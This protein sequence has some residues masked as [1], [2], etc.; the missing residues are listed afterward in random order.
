LL[1][2]EAA[3]TGL[4]RLNRE[5]SRQAGRKTP[6]A[7][8]VDEWNEFGWDAERATFAHND[9]PEPYD[10]AH[11]L[12]SAGFLN[13]FL[14]HAADVGMANYSPTINCRGFV[15]ADRRGVLLRPDYYVF[16][17]Y[18]AGMGGVALRARVQAAA[19]EHARAPLLDV[20]AVRD[21]HGTVHLFAVNRHARLATR[22]RI[23][24]AHFHSGR[25]SAQQLTAVSLESYNDFDHPRSVACAEVSAN[26][27]GDVFDYVFPARSLTVLHLPEASP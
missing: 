6:L 2:V 23:T 12:Y 24:L 9:R 17:M 27:S 13:I 8:A 20:A 18:R 4:S 25:A 10:L 7:L 5:V 15:Y 16:Q 3:I 19:L 11:A 26:I 21:P 1:G 14:R 22:C